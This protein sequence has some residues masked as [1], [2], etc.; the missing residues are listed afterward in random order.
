MALSP[1]KNFTTKH[2]EMNPGVRP[3]NL[4]LAVASIL[5]AVLALSFGDAVIKLLSSD[6]SLW[7]IYIMRSALALPVVIAI[8]KLHHR[9]LSL[10][11]VALGWTT[12]RSCLLGFM[13]IA[14]YAALPHVKLSVAAA[15]YY[16]IPLF[17]T[18]FSALFAGE[19]VKPKSWLAI[20]IGFIGVLVIVRPASDEFNAYVLLPLLAAILYALAMILTRTKCR[21]ENPR[22][23]SFTLNV[24]FIAMG[25][26]AT[27]LLM[28]AS[29]D[30]EQ[31][32][33][34]PFLLSEWRS[35]VLDDWLAMSVLATVVI[36]GSIFAAVAYQNGP[37]SV[38]ATFD[39]SYLAFSALWGFVIFV[40][41]PDSL[42][43]F[44]MCLIVVAGL[45]VLKD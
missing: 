13:W 39:Y 18:L 10:I 31:I 7:Q 17:I 41:I 43:V 30:N 40:E 12:L 22:V 32:A 28:L 15:V 21:N 27:L 29:H 44:G 37:S 35:P 4:K 11:P 16:T 38:I 25:F 34:N 6:L 2:E 26:I 24:T 9:K 23:L 36:I 20:V 5:F 14:Y 33:L 45:M 19:R 42:A 8:V 3:D 1:G